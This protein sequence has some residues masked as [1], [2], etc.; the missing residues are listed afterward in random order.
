MRRAYLLAGGQSRRF[1]SDKARVEVDGIPN[2]VRLAS[3]LHVRD[4]A[5]TI[6][7][8]SS[9]DYKDLGFISIEDPV[10]DAGPLAGF[11]A[12]LAHCHASRTDYC[13]ISNCDLVVDSWDWLEAMEQ[14]VHTPSTSIVIF[15]SEDFMPLPGIYAS[16]VLKAAERI[17]EEGCRSLKELHRQTQE[18][19]HRL[20]WPIEQRPIPFNTPE[21]LAMIRKIR[22]DTA[23]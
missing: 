23:N 7:S 5:V 11:L 15:D 19:I 16:R 3:D 8:Q 14:R 1:G 4:W 13:L 10:P 21:E 9:D 12:A 17:W 6:V 18:T 20:K 22:G 2:I